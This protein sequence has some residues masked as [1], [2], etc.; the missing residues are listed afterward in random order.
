MGLQSGRNDLCTHT[1]CRYY[2]YVYVQHTYSEYSLLVHTYTRFTAMYSR[3]E[4]CMLYYFV[5]S[6]SYLHILR[7]MHACTYYILYT[8]YIYIYIYTY[9]HVLHAFKM[10][11]ALGFYVYIIF[12]KK[13]IKIFFFFYL[14]VII[15]FFT[16]I[17][18]STLDSGCNMPAIIV[19]EILLHLWIR[20]RIVITTY[21]KRKVCMSTTMTM[22]AHMYVYV[23]KY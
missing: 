21:G 6:K 15:P 1:V 16:S 11:R 10:Y 19:K 3:R 23:Y 20:T 18:P 7:Y 9:I 17:A 22:S 2:V 8:I 12:T 13:M 5:R 4:L 14:K